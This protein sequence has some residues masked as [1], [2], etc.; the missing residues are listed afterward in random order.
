MGK[1][2]Y[3]GN[4]YQ[5]GIED[6][7]HLLIANGITPILE[8]DAAAPGKQQATTSLQPLRDGDQSL[9]RR[10]VFRQA[11]RGNNALIFDLFPNPFLDTDRH[12]GAP[13]Q[14]WLLLT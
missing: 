4:T 3:G 11:Y 6:Y 13:C 7:V 5:D 12:M 10:D 2:P 8:L 9:L 1:S 14:R